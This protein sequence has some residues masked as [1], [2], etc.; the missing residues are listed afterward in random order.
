MSLE[1]LDILERAQEGDHQAFEILVRQFKHRVFATALHITGNPSDAD[2]VAQETFV[3]VYRA[4]SKFDRRSKF[5]TWL[6][7]I[8]VNT[9]LNHLRKAKRQGKVRTAM[10]EERSKN[11]TQ[12]SPNHGKV[13]RLQ[14]VM[15]ALLSLSEPLKI[16]LVLAAVEGL[17]YSE[18]A[19][20]LEIPE[21][22]V[23]WRVS[24]ARKKLREE[25]TSRENKGPN[26]SD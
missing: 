22:T 6:Y 24:E 19:E 12:A 16:T 17:S 20:V 18:I 1:I 9:A 10:L 11:P 2:D 5:S 15:D 26:N 7:R 3:R 8:T 4:L 25:I 23:A 14:M 13:K 21:G